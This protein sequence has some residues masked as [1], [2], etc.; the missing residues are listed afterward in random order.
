VPTDAHSRNIEHPT[1]GPTLTVCGIFAGVGGIELG[2]S[3]AGHEIVS[4]CEVDEPARCVLVKHFRDAKLLGDIRQVDRLPRADVLAAGFPCQDLSP[5]GTAK[6]I[7]GE[8]SSLV[9]ELFKLVGEAQQKPRWILLENVPFMLSL[10]RGKAMRFVTK[11]LEEQGYRWAYRTVDTRA[12]GIPQRR[13]RVFLL[14]SRTEDPRQVL[15]ADDA[16]IEPVSGGEPTACGFYWTEGNTGIGWAKDAV[17]TL[18][19]S[20]GLGIPSPPAVWVRAGHTI[21]TL[22]VRDAERLQGFPADWTEPAAFAKGGRAGIRW[23]LIGN[24]VSVPVSAW[25][26]R[27]LACPG[28]FVPPSPCRLKTSDRWPAAAWG[29]KKARFLVEASPWPVAEKMTRLLDFLKHPRKPLSAKATSGFLCRVRA[30]NLRLADGFLDDL[31]RHLAVVDPEEI[32]P[33]QFTGARAKR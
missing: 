21:Q 17:P 5:A 18:K 16:G 7:K 32:L 8:K 33:R 31:E 2:V 3:R 1:N 23:R 6:G 19:G 14:A 13:R 25:L 9:M 10:Q 29:E 30:S 4:L 12:F 28:S 15:F 27:K 24:A 22:D 20:S 11:Q 26:G